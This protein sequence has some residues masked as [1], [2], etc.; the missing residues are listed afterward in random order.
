M[1]GRP[2][3][4]FW[5]LNYAAKEATYDATTVPGAIWHKVNGPGLIHH[6]KTEET[7]QDEITGNPYVSDA[8]G[9]VIEDRVNGSIEFKGSVDLLTYFYAMLF[10]NVATTGA[11]PFT[12]AIT[13]PGSGVLSPFS[14]SLIQATD[15]GNIANTQK[16][17]A[18]V[19]PNSIELVIE[20]P[21]SVQ[22]TVEL[23]GSGTQTADTTAIPA[24]ASAVEGIRLRYADLVMKFGPASEDISTLFRRLTLRAT[25][26][27]RQ[28]PLPGSGTTVGEIHYGPQAPI[29]E[30]ELVVKGQKGDTLYNYWANRTKVI[31][32]MKLTSGA[33]SLAIVANSTMINADAGE[34]ESFDGIDHR[35]TLPFRFEYNVAATTPFTI[36]GI[37]SVATYLA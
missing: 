25:A 9:S 8:G 27:V 12:H 36:T 1:P 13:W 37:N 23:Q 28:I 15:R 14:V 29:L 26:D 22:A 7:D 31:F 21:G 18:G 10:A 30:G 33:N 4:I 35:L 6:T 5:L 17:F 2:Q 3:D 19:Y 34:I 20:N 32:D 16:E 11:G 24:I